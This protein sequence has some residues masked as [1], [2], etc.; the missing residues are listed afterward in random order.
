MS[1]LLQ[2]SPRFS[3]QSTPS[4]LSLLRYPGLALAPAGLAAGRGARRVWTGETHPSQTEAPYQARGRET[5]AAGPRRS[6]R[7]RS[8]GL[9]PGSRSLHSRQPP[10][11]GRPQSLRPS[12]RP[13]GRST[14]RDRV[15]PEPPR[16]RCQG[17][18][19]ADWAPALA[20]ARGSARAGLSAG[21][22]PA[23]RRPHPH[24]GGRRPSPRPPLGAPMI[25]RCLSAV[26]G[27]CRYSARGFPL[28]AGRAAVLAVGAAP[29][30]PSPG[31]ARSALR[32]PQRG[33][34]ATV[35]SPLP[36]RAP[37]PLC[38]G[39]PRQR[40]ATHVAGS[41]HSECRTMGLRRKSFDFVPIGKCRPVIKVPAAVD[42][43]TVIP[44]THRSS[45]QIVYITVKPLWFG[46]LF[47][48]VH[49]F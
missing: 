3:L 2:D 45:V 29:T 48:P 13:A 31:P 33:P 10:K 22:P 17:R 7:S 35:P 6:E 42:S 32:D 47:L 44:L 25:A 19:G 21:L 26:R 49:A 1:N 16:G 34:G 20:P 18:G 4:S 12:P 8:S 40:S 41:A 11:L 37:I 5:A 15:A 39:L 9:E 38:L 43:G 46:C 27:L 14:S 30:A 24:A 23:S 28:A 36:G